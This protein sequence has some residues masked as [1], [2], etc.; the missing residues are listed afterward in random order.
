M[1]GL[2]LKPD[3]SPQEST[4][5]ITHSPTSPARAVIS[6]AILLLSF[7]FA[8]L[9]QQDADISVYRERGFIPLLDSLQDGEYDAGKY[10]A[11]HTIT[12]FCR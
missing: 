6:L 8:L 7:P 4:A 9:A 12:I 1:F 11:N 3:I 5:V 10:L 2:V